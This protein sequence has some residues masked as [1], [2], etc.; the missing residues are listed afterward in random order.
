M[1]QTVLEALSYGGTAIALVL[2]ALVLSR[3]LDER[4]RNYPLAILFTAFL[5]ALT[6][7]SVVLRYAPNAVPTGVSF[8][9]GYSFAELLMHLLLLA[10]MLQL[11]SQ[12]LALL[13]QATGIVWLLAGI[14]AL[15][16]VAAYLYFDGPPAVVFVKVRQVVSFWMVLVNLYWWSL[17]IRTRKIDRRI[18]L[19]SAGI[20]LLMTGQVV[21]DGVMAMANRRLWMYMIALPVMF[22]THYACLYSW[23][24]AFSVANAP[25]VGT[26]SAAR[27]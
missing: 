14:S 11:A 27:R 1:A 21:G 12:T 9:T 3:F 5:F 13:G 15:V 23:F 26:V 20:G 2:Q 17:M 19:L 24:R 25:T 16:G 7:L 22:L 10:L 8:Q 18:L 4:N 6:G